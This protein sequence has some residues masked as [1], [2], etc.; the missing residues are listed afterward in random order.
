[1]REGGEIRKAEEKETGVI[2]Y[3]N[4]KKKNRNLKSKQENQV[5]DIFIFQSKF[6]INIGLI[7]VKCNLYTLK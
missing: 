6:K 1:M 5:R 4:E 3:E 2:E 7:Y